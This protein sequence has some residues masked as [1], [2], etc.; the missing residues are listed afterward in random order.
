MSAKKLFLLLTTFLSLFFITSKAK[1]VNYVT[2]ASNVKVKMTY[3]D[4]H[5]NPITAMTFGSYSAVFSYHTSV[6]FSV[7]AKYLKPGNNIGVVQTE[8]N[9]NNKRFTEEVLARR[10]EFGLGTTITDK[11]GKA[12]GYIYFLQVKNKGYYYFHVTASPSEGSDIGMQ[13]FVVN[14]GTPVN[15]NW[16]T[17]STVFKETGTNP[18]DGDWWIRDYNGTQLEHYPVH[19]TPSRFYPIASP[20]GTGFYDISAGY[21][22]R[23]PD[24]TGPVESVEGLFYRINKNTAVPVGDPGFDVNDTSKFQI[25]VNN[26]TNGIYQFGVDYKMTADAPFDKEIFKLG[27]GGQPNPQGKQSM[28]N[29]GDSITGYHDMAVELISPENRFI[30]EYMG[31]RYASDVSYGNEYSVYDPISKKVLL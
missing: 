6:S 16:K 9:T 10:N 7:D 24:Y 29:P 14:N 8:F 3:D 30:N 27:I 12:I 22:V 28:F 26:T 1:A 31:F 11:S 4:K 17:H 15:T 5:K 20:L 19:L 23:S 25:E 2:N 21:N 13:D 18:I